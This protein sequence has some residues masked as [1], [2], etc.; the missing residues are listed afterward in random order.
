VELR[1]THHREADVDEEFLLDE[2]HRRPFK[3]VREIGAKLVD[4]NARCSG[5][6]DELC[7]GDAIMAVKRLTQIGKGKP[8]FIDFE[9]GIS[10]CRIESDERSQLL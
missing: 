3:Q 8:I 1:L 9:T 5:R 10:F 7:R 6:C 4:T 2:Y